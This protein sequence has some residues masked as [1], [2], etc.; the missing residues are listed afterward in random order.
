MMRSCRD[1]CEVSIEKSVVEKGC[2][3]SRECSLILDNE[4]LASWRPVLQDKPL[5][6]RMRSRNHLVVEP[7][8]LAWQLEQV[9]KYAIFE[10]RP[11]LR[12]TRCYS[13][14]WVSLGLTSEID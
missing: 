3:C 8:Y 5:C 4:G 12:L 11:V 14:I 7:T 9:N 10:T 13:L 2:E 1:E 6:S